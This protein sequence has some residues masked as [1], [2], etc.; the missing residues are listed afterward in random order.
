VST[1][2][3]QRWADWYVH[4]LDDVVAWQ[5]RFINSLGFAGYY[6]LL[7]PGSGTKPERYASDVANYL[8]DGVT[9]VGAVWH[10]FYA[11]LPDRRRVVAYVSSMA[12]ETS[13]DQSCA[14]GDG[15][16]PLT[17]RAVNG[18]Q[19]ARWIA[20]IA[21]EY[22]LPASGENPGYNYPSRLNGHYRDTSSSGMMA[23]SIRQMSS[24]GF[25]GMYWAHDQ[26]LWDG[27]VS[28][29]RYAGWISATNGS[30]SPAPPMP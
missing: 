14:A 16:V 26:R 7:T 19:A 3:V 22:H 25:Q 18:W 28:F 13:G 15:T 21:K 2:Q 1:S 10:K 9:G 11:D 5:M 17:G 27:T 30:V 8:P 24:C 4:G 23:A 12:N 20:R 6:Q 29:S